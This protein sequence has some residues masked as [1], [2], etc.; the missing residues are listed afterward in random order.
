MDDQQPSLEL[1]EGSTTIPKGST[2]S[3]GGSGEHPH[4]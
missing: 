1:E 3:L 2:L 4:G